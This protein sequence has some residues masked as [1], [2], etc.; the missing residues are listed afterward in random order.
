MRQGADLWHRRAI[1]VADAV[2]GTSLTV[3]GL[4]NT[5]L[6]K[7]PA[8]TQPGT[9]L[10]VTGKGLPNFLRRGRGDLH[11]TIDVEVPS[12]LSAD[13]RHLYE[14]LRESPRTV[15]R[16]LWRRRSRPAAT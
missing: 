8:G 3:S 4:E 14:Q 1:R 9:V 2:L 7:V 16:R 13:E 12:C 6:V 5:V 15:K 10:H 11:L